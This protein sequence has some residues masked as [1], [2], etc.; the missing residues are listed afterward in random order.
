MT[1]VWFY[2]DAVLYLLKQTVHLMQLIQAASWTCMLVIAGI[3]AASRSPAALL[4]C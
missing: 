3:T 2:A 4:T 1:C